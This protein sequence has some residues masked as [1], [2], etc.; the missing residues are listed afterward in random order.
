MSE[1]FKEKNRIALIIQNSGY[2]EHK[3]YSRKDDDG[4]PLPNI[5][6]KSEKK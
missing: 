4:N 6:D 1:I 5:Y 3:F 2:K